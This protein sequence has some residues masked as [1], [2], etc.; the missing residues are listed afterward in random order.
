MGPSTL[1][2]LYT[3]LCAGRDVSNRPVAQFL[4]EGERLRA[5]RELAMAM[6]DKKVIVLERPET[7]AAISRARLPT[8]TRTPP[9]G[10]ANALGHGLINSHPDSY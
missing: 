7:L 5:C 2:E 4:T 6:L 3:Q 9:A 10:R 1:Y 8:V